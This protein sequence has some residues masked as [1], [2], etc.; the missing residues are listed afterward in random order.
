[1]AVAS[2][3]GFFIRRLTNTIFRLNRAEFGAAVYSIILIANISFAPRE[4]RE[5]I[6]RGVLPKS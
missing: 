3:D 2:S 1:M 6:P 4:Y 5:A